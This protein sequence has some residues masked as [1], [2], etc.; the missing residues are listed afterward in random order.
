MTTIP[1]I[2][3]YQPDLTLLETSVLAIANH[4]EI[5]WRTAVARTDETGRCHLYV[6]HA[7]VFA[8]LF[9]PDGSEM[10]EPGTAAAT[11]WEQAF[12]QSLTEITV[13]DR[14]IR[15][16]KALDHPQL[17]VYCAPNFLAGINSPVVLTAPAE[18]CR[19][20]YIMLNASLLA[21]T[22]LPMLDQHAQHLDN[23][24]MATWAL[25]MWKLGFDAADVIERYHLSKPEA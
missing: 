24:R 14:K 2:I 20:P 3:T 11:A 18:D 21:V 17:I 5:A 6:D 22:L 25:A 1:S 7:A 8:L 4:P 13:N 19:P 15:I 16:P 12:G 23:T 10:V 9:G